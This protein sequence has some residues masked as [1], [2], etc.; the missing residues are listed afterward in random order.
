MHEMVALWWLSQCSFISL[1]IEGLFRDIVG[2]MLFTS[3][4]L[5][6]LF[7]ILLAYAH[8]QEGFE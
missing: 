3:S 2:T 5:A 7:D 8:K 6:H 1:I 4:L